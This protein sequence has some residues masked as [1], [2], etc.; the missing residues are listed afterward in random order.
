MSRVFRLLERWFAYLTNRLIALTEGERKDYIDLKV[1][2]PQKIHTIHSGVDIARF[3]IPSCDGHEKKRQLG[4]DPR[5]VL[6]GFI[7]W[8]LPIKG[9]MHLLNAMDKVWHKH[10]GVSLVFVGKGQLEAD[11]KIKAAGMPMADRVSFLGWRQ[12][13]AEI[14]QLLDILVV[15]S[16]NEG[17]GRVLVEAMAAAK[18][19]V[20]SLTGG[21][22][23]LVRHNETGLLVPP[24]NQAALAE[25]IQWLIENPE[26]A[27]L[28]GL[29]GRQRCEQF[30][31]QAM[32][33]KLDK[34]YR[35]LLG[36]EQGGGEKESASPDCHSRSEVLRGSGECSGPAEIYGPCGR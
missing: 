25:S 21:I 12:D 22:P 19:V 28:M 33:E 2:G 18:P 14:M 32:I 24:G 7:G 3:Q 30:S 27:R 17:M 23:D 11:L 26:D 9:P 36:E 4:L 5:D 13:V 10:S 20:A 16:L 15:P 35:D 1:C 6:V 29:K 8:L 31:L 34:L